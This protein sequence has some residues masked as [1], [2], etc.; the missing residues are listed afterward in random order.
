MDQ[1]FGPIGQVGTQA[2]GGQMSGDSQLAHNI[3]QHLS[4]ALAAVNDP[5]LRQ[6]LATAMATLHKYVAARHKE[7]LDA[8]AGKASVRH[9]SH[10]YG[11]V[12]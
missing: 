2:S 10:V 7:N 11:T 12:L 5:E 4:N 8:L 1:G 6:S 3:S 9:L